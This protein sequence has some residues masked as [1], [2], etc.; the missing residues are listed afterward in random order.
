[1]FKSS[2]SYDTEK[3]V[4]FPR[5]IEICLFGK[6]D[7]LGYMFQLREKYTPKHLNIYT[8]CHFDDNLCESEIKSVDSLQY[9]E[10][11]LYFIWIFCALWVVTLNGAAWFVR[12]RYDSEYLMCVKCI[13]HPTSNVSFTCFSPLT[14]NCMIFHWVTR[15]CRSKR[16]VR[17][18]QGLKKPQRRND[19]FLF[20]S[21][22]DFNL[23]LDDKTWSITLTVR[24]CHKY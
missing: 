19:K 8:C 18:L 11:S 20:R 9:Q 12:I 2:F 23:K 6:I 15:M 4:F 14:V 5:K 16:D 21:F 13:G 17:L 7:K 1:M 22:R 10:F 24:E 3:M